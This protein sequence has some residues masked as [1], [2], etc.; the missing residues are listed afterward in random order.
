MRSYPSAG[1]D[2]L[3]EMEAE[4]RDSVSS[5]TL[6]VRTVTETV[7]LIHRIGYWLRKIYLIVGKD[8]SVV[9]SGLLG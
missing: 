1:H 9:C 5:E 8:G 6:L 2:S 3:T 4:P 7:R